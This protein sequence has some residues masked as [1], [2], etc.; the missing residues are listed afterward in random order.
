[1]LFTPCDPHPQELTS[2][3]GERERVRKAESKKEKE[4]GCSHGLA[5]AAAALEAASA[6]GRRLWRKRADLLL[7]CI[8]EPPWRSR[9]REAWQEEAVAEEAPSDR[10]VGGSLYPIGRLVDVQ[11]TKFGRVQLSMHHTG[12]NE[13]LSADDLPSPHRSV[14]PSTFLPNRLLTNRSSLFLNK[15]PTMLHLLV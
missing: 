3:W 4:S 10:T 11:W 5:A 8:S 12:P 2:T 13:T 6:I 14:N 9:H 15:T 1:M 7:F